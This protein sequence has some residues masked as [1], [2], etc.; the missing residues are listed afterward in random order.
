MDGDKSPSFVS[1]YDFEILC[2][3]FKASIGGGL[4]PRS[5]WVSHVG[6]L[7]RDLTG[8]EVADEELISRIMLSAG[9][10]RP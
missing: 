8:D 2:Q 3:A 4:V 6:D 1:A 10:I 7:I 9:A 5:L